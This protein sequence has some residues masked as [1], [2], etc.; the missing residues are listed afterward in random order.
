MPFCTKNMISDRR[1]HTKIFCI[2]L[3]VSALTLSTQS[4]KKSCLSNR[5]SKTSIHYTLCNSQ[6]FS[7]HARTHTPK[8]P[9]RNRRKLPT[10]KQYRIHTFS[11]EPNTIHNS[12]TNRHH[13][14]I[15]FAASF[16]QNHSCQIS[17]IT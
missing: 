12:I 13:P 14:Y 2:P 5:I 9:I 1:H 3:P 17:H 4:L 10:L 11:P 16:R 15:S 8:T 7:I 6:V